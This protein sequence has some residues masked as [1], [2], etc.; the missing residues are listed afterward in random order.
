MISFFF[1]AALFLIYVKDELKLQ[2]FLNV[3]TLFV[4]IVL[5]LT[6]CCL[7]EISPLSIYVSTLELILTGNQLNLNYGKTFHKFI[8]GLN[9]LSIKQIRRT[10]S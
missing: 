7:H 4:N 10:R 3:T 9:I 1:S 8:K 6:F 2:P 5:L